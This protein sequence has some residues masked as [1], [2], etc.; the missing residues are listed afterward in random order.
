[1]YSLFAL[2]PI[3]HSLF[4]TV[5]AAPSFLNHSEPAYCPGGNP[6]NDVQAQPAL[7]GS[8]FFKRQADQPRCGPSQGNQL[9]GLGTCCSGTGFC[10]TG[11]DFCSVPQ[12][13]QPNYGFCDSDIT[14]TGPDTSAEQ[15]NAQGPVPYGQFIFNCTMPQTLA[16][17]YDD[18]PSNNTQELLDILMSAGA[19][20]TFFVSGNTNGKGAIDRTPE[21]VSAIKRMDAEGH[22]IG[23]HTWSHP[24]LNNLSSE[25][26]GVAMRKNERAIANILNKY[27]TYM[28]PPYEN[29]NS[30]SGCL[31]DMN[32]LGYHVVAHSLDSQDWANPDNLSAMVDTFDSGLGQ[33]LPNGSM[34]LMQ[35][36]RFSVSAINLTR[37]ILMDITQRGWKVSTLADCLGDDTRNWYRTPSRTEPATMAIDGCVV[38]RNG[39][40]GTLN[41]FT[42]KQ[43]C[44][45]SNRNCYTQVDDCNSANKGAVCDDMKNI[46]DFQS[47]YC[48]SCGTMTPNISC[49]TKDF[50][51]SNQP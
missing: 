37:Y 9:C 48:A 35:H 42:N 44:D 49:E 31:T 19:N 50:G 27:P 22:Q 47:L 26:R 6:G 13:C 15:R 17:T 33:A 46:C 16:L 8:V 24:D 4:P 1:M 43:E 10:G 5:F 12:N 20:A 51:F 45:D 34:L 38:S 2:L 28:R 11:S 21:W 18:G 29:C 39:F 40:C 3:L 41:V 36:E 25:D 14:P 30:E 7:L 23:S 32:N